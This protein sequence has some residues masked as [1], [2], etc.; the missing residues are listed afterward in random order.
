M[1][2]IQWLKVGER[3][4]EA[5][6]DRGVL[7]IDNAPGVPW[8]GLIAVTKN[9]SGGEVKPRYLDGIKIGNRTSSEEFDATI[10]AYTFPTQFEQCDGTALLQNGLRAKQQ[11]RKEFHMSYRSRI[12]ND[13][14]GL[15]LA[16][17]IHIL[18]NL[19]AE[20]S[21]RSFQTL[22][23]Q[24][25]AA[26]FNW[27]ITSRAPKV[28]GLYPTTHYVLDNRDIPAEL[29]QIV[30]DMIYGTADTDPALPTPGELI[31]LFDSYL[32]EVYDAGSPYTPVFETYDAGHPGDPYTFEIDGGA[33]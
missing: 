26:T 27:H 33:P 21:N 8:N 18:Y 2:K 30:E 14:K 7:Y 13:I 29:M 5:G 6:I 1:T 4:Y 24:S 31:F 17:Q 20:P 19:R 10:E 23:A 25:Q 11:S 32:D 12:G 28:A 9:Q 16:Y 22:N 3:F 15:D